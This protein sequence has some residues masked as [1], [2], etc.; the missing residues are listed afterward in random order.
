MRSLFGPFYPGAEPELATRF[1]E[2]LGEKLKG[3]ELSMAALQQ[4]FIAMRKKSAAEAAERRGGPHHRGARGARQQRVV[5]AE[6][7]G[8]VN[9]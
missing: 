5:A 1:Q 8:F 7:D 9:A 3:R 6:G 2:L 4:Y